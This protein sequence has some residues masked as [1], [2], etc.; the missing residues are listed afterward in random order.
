MPTITRKPSRRPADDKEPELTWFSDKQLAE[1]ASLLNV[2]PL[3]MCP[4]C[5]A[6]AAISIWRYSTPVPTI[7][8]R[9]TLD[10]MR[11]SPGRSRRG[12]A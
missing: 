4:L 8:I 7:E 11:Q 5:Q 10:E 6:A 9:D 2:D 1:L 12:R 3:E